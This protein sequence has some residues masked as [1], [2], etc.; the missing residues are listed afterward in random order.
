[1]L[2]K[3]INL[4][5]P[6]IASQQKISTALTNQS[7]IHIL[8]IISASMLFF[9]PFLGS[10]HLFDW[11]EN[12][13]AEAAREMIMTGDYSR[14][15]ID[16]QPFWEKPPLF[17]WLQTISMHIWGINEFAARFP[18]AIFGMLALITV[19]LIGKKL[20]DPKFGLLWA[21]FYFGS[22]L[23][24]FYFKSG[25]IDP[26]FNFFIFTSIYFLASSLKYHEE[27]RSTKYAFLSG[28][29][30]GLAILAKGP[31]GFLILFLTFVSF[32]VINRL[33]KVGPLK[34]IAIFGITAFIVTSAWYLIE[35]IK[36]GPWFI[37][38]FI[39]YQIR[40]FSTPDA[41]HKQPFYFHFL[42]A[43]LGCF[44]A[45]VFAIRSFYKKHETDELNFR[46]WMLCMFWV[47]MI[48]FTIV[49]TKLL[50]YTSLTYYA[51]SFLAA[52]H[53][54]YILEQKSSFNK[55]TK[56]MFLFIGT[57]L[58]VIFILLPIVGYNLDKIIPH[59]KDAA[60]INAMQTP[61]GWNGFEFLIG[62]IYLIALYIG[63]AYL[64]SGRIEKGIITICLSTAVFLFSFTSVVVPKIEI[65]SQGVAIEFYKSLEG[66][67]AYVTTVGFRSYAHYFYTKKPKPE[68]NLSYDQQWLLEGDIDKPVYF[69]TKSN[70][71]HKL[72]PYPD[73][74]LLK[75]AGGFAFFKREKVK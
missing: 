62:T 17:I 55:M 2:Q 18:N 6:D 30:I 49:T 60:A 44:P 50:H 20:Y 24:H 43:L 69:V 73:I 71:T 67:D 25:I 10:V 57:L 45:S 54:Y 46:K 12:I 47:V 32:L 26:V 41:G 68:N 33:K 7:K 19:Y 3:K 39:S 29:L 75:T 11:D 74:R 13:Y 14:V 27:K 9:L 48:L 21:L 64:N 51:L 22:L 4:L 70:K 58:A 35:L 1:M 65:Y 53:V 40:V 52:Y 42:V 8:A 15:M 36:N 34:N 61:A 28:L 56:L 16:Y 72:E 31:V 23:P 38:E 59:V 5:D 63:W 37:T 66:E